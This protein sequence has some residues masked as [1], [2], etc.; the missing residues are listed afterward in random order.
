MGRLLYLFSIISVAGVA[1]LAEMYEVR[2][3][4][5][6]YA[7]LLCTIVIICLVFSFGDAVAHQYTIWGYGYQHSLHT[8]FLGVEVET[9]LFAVL[10]GLAVAIPTLVWA[11][12]VDKH[13]SFFAGIRPRKITKP[14]NTIKK[15]PTKSRNRKR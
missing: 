4:L 10:T 8:R 2:T 11:E 15:R 6:K 12:D 5:H 14:K 1:L 9:I 13:R 7:R 3:R